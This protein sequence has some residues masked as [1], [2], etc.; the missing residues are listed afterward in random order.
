MKIRAIGEN[1]TTYKQLLG[2]DSEWY[3]LEPIAASYW[4]IQRRKKKLDPK[5]TY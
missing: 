2:E 1:A 3:K 4:V 5:S